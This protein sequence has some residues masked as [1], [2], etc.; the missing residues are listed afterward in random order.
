MSG[1]LYGRTYPAMPIQEI[2]LAVSL[3]AGAL[4]LLAALR[5]HPDRIAT[6]KPPTEPPKPGVYWPLL[7]G[8]GQREFDQT[9]RLAIVR[10][11]ATADKDWRLPILLCA[12]EQETDPEM[13]AA[14]HTA[15]GDA[16]KPVI[17]TPPA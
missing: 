11:L 12:R 14:I 2:G 5:R 6:P 9:M 1:L 7:L 4:F 3:F 16:V 8:T 13:L 17:G 15:L 10:Q